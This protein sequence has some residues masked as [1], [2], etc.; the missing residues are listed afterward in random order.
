MGL[1]GGGSR[2]IDAW[3]LDDRAVLRSRFGKFEC[4]V[5]YLV[6]SLDVTRCSKWPPHG[7]FDDQRPWDAQLPRPVFKCLDHDCDGRYARFF[8]R[9]CYVPDRHVTHWS[10]RNQE[11]QIDVLVVQFLHPMGQH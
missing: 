8:D 7:V 1:C 6:V 3:E 11:H 9:S 2:T 4:C 10:D 5:E